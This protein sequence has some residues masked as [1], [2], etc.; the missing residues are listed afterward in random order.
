MSSE[1][2]KITVIIPAYNARV[3]IGEALES[4]REQGYEALEVVVVDDGSQDGTADYVETGWP[5]VQVVRKNNGGA[6]T[7]RNAGL[8][9]AS[10]E[11]IAFM[12][13]DDVW[14]P[15]KL[16]TQVR[17]LERHPEAAI[18]CSGFRVWQPDE[19]GDY[20][21]PQSLVAD[22]DA[23]GETLDPEYSGWI[24][25]R[26][27]LDSSVWTSTVMM[28]RSLVAQ[29]GEFDETLRLGQD[30]DYWLRAA[31]LTEIHTLRRPLA[32]YR[33]HA[34]SATARG[35]P[36]NYGA[37][38]LTRALKRWGTSSPNGASVPRRQV[39]HRIAGIH[40]A[41]GF[42]HYHRGNHARA[43]PEFASAVRLRPARALWWAYLLLATLKALRGR[44]QSPPQSRG[45]G[46]A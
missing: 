23:E 41:N 29:L 13:A 26:L 4:V 15:G 1:L 5:W 38:V 33:Q 36:V 11:Y 12:D 31:Q 43:R 3:H 24:Y 9:V 34:H 2:P 27:L 18:V 6:A 10:G 20:P 17:F 7:A 39:L 37:R 28:R 45:N 21:P 16:H 14:L 35:A 46:A 19:Q 22:T 42:H 40:F 30:Y 44:D 32:L 25:H 8:R